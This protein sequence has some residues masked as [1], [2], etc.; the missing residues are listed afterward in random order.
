[1]AE[2]VPHLGEG[3]PRPTFTV[4]TTAVVGGTLVEINGNMTVG[5]AGAASTKVVGVASRDVAVGSQ[6]MVFASGIHDLVASGAIA[7]GAQ[8][9]AGAA[10]TV[11]TVGAGTAFQVI[12]TACEAIA[13]TASG[14]ILLNRVS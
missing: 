9:I 10:G 5:P 11:A 14:R 7:A 2:H 8:V 4:A 12:G 1:M 3:D 6:V 13:D